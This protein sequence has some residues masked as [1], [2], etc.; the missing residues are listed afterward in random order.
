MIF[1]IGVTLKD[2][3]ERGLK[4]LYLLACLKYGFA[5][6]TQRPDRK[7][8][9]RVK[10]RPWP[11]FIYCYTQRPDRKG[12]ERAY[13]ADTFRK[14]NRVTLKDPIERGLKDP[15]ELAMIL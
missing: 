10:E 2:P 8:T 5:S 1:C 15:K 4:V 11:W 6:Y 7:G 9:E 13:Q 12:T 14:V 3:I